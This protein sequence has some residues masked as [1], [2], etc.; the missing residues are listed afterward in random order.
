M[1]IV[2]LAFTVNPVTNVQRAREFYEG[3]LGLTP[4]V[5]HEGHGM[6]WVEYEVGPG[7]LALGFGVEQFKP[8]GDGGTVALE[9]ENFEEAIRELKERGCRFI[10]EPMETPVCRMAGVFDS[11]G[12]TLIIHKRKTGSGTQ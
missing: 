11:E 3:V 1:K 8:S 4:S 2:E 10:F 5:V 12:N 7:V 6:A 9:M